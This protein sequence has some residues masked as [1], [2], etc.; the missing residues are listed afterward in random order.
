MRTIGITEHIKKEIEE[1]RANP[2]D[3]E[4]WIDVMILA[5]DGY[6][7]AGGTANLLMDHLLAKQAKNFSRKW[8]APQAE[9]VPM[10]HVR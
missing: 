8:P 2:S 10:E 9:D 3:V 1:I 5:L 6:W 4:E 7:R